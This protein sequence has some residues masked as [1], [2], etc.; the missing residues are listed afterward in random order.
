[1]YTRY[2]VIEGEPVKEPAGELWG[3]VDQCREEHCDW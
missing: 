1:M 2:V 3:R